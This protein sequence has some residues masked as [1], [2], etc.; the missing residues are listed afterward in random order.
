MPAVCAK[1]LRAWKLTQDAEAEEAG[2]RWAGNPQNLVFTTCFGRPIEPSNIN[3]A[4][5]S[6]AR[7]AK[8]RTLH[9]HALRHACATFLQAQGVDMWVIRDILGHSKLSITSDL[10]SHVLLPALRDA[11]KRMDKLMGGE[12]SEPLV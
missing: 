9:P 11:I 3:R 5:S 6:L 10:Y 8:L 7:R 4:L 1:A 12:D 2:D